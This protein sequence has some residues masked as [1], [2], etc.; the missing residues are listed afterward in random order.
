MAL[1]ALFAFVPVIGIATT[2]GFQVGKLAQKGAGVRALYWLTAIPGLLI[3]SIFLI[4][5]A[6]L[7][8]WGQREASIERD[9]EA[10][11]RGIRRS[12]S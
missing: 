5:L 4:A 1:F 3:G 2:A 11:A 10:I 8:I 7:G 12:G 6:A 9:A